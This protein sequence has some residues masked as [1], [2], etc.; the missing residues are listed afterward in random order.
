MRNVTRIA[1][2][3]QG[4]L[5][6]W[7]EEV[8]EEHRVVQRKRKFSAVTLVRT[9]VL[10]MLQKPKATVNDLAAAAALQGVDVSPQAV[11]QR[12]TPQLANYMEQLFRR[13]VRCAI[14]LECKAAAILERFSHVFVLDSSTITL[15]DELED[16]FP[17][18]GGSH[19]GG[20]AAMKIQT[21]WD[22]RTGALHTLSLEAGRQCD[23][24]TPVQ[25]APMPAGSLRITDLGYFDLDVLEDVGRANN[26]WLSRLQFGTNVY[27]SAGQLLV[28]MHWL[29]QQTDRI[30]DAQVKLGTQHKLPC[31]LLAWRVPAEVANL[32]RAKLIAETK[33][34]RGCQPTEERLAWC[35]WTILATNVSQDLL[36]PTEALV[37]YRARWQVELLFK[38]WKSL[39]LIDEMTGAT[40]TEQMVRLWTRLLVVL[41]EHWTLLAT[42]WGDRRVSLTKACKAIRDHA[43][44]LARSLDSRKS[45][46]ETF[47]ALQRAIQKTA[48][49][50][51]RKRKN[52]FELLENPML[53]EEAL[54]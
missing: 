37:L 11:A 3:V 23:Y 32:R 34:K 12:F 17:G 18:C 31:R 40:T 27:T 41:L 39:G 16:R 9:L 35:D 47:T 30:I 43:T 53:I 22:L 29:S 8:N 38:R 44:L 52:T 20:R 45:L 49:Y 26:Y 14:G 25:T 19:G 36:T 2:A 24:K 50:N 51:K 4:L 6:I 28:L 42:A 5:G 46:L 10:G 1:L 21:Q 7:A 33:R 13:A 15:P 48:R 54:T